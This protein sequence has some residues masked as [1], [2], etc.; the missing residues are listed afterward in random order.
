MRSGREKSIVPIGVTLWLPI[1]QRHI[2]LD[3]NL[4]GTTANRVEGDIQMDSNEVHRIRMVYAQQ[5]LTEKSVWDNPMRWLPCRW[6]DV[7]EKRKDS[8]ASA[9][10]LVCSGAN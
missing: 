1:G 5:E 9:L 8:A 2:E 4:I 10:P 3:G 7:F 6:S